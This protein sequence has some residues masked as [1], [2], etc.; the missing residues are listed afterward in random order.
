M[1]LYKISKIYSQSRQPIILENFEMENQEYKKSKEEYEKV[2]KIQTYL[3]NSEKNIQNIQNTLQNNIFHNVPMYFFIFPLLVSYIIYSYDKDI[4]NYKNL[5]LSL[6]DSNLVFENPYKSQSQTKDVISGDI[7][8]DFVYF[9]MQPITK[10]FF[11]PDDFLRFSFLP[12]GLNKKLKE[13]IWVFFF[14]Y[15][16]I[17]FGILYIIL[18]ENLVYLIV[19]SIFYYQLFKKNFIKFSEAITLIL[20]VFLLHF[21]YDLDILSNKMYNFIF[22]PINIYIISKNFFLTNKDGGQKL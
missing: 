12:T 15:V 17:F 18:P 8:T 13:H 6:K 16:L 4:T 1:N 9:V 14:V 5:I 7:Y 22:Y 10:I 19:Y 21:L 11:D 3:Q 20:I 2:E